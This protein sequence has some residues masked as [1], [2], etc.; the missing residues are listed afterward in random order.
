MSD[1]AGPTPFIAIFAPDR[2]SVPNQLTGLPLKRFAFQQPLDLIGI[3]TDKMGPGLSCGSPVM[4]MKL[5]LIGIAL[6][7]IIPIQDRKSLQ[8]TFTKYILP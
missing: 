2:I 8:N 3:I 7:E 1:P 6:H 4:R 5:D